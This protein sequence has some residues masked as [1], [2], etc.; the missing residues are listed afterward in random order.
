MDWRTVTIAVA[1]YGMAWIFLWPFL[2]KLFG[3][4]FAVAK[5]DA[6]I[7]GGRPTYGFLTF[8]SDPN[9]PLHGIFTSIAGH[10]VTDWLFMVGLLGIGVAL[11]LGIG[12]R[13]ACWSGIVMLV[14]M[15]LAILPMDSGTDHN[16]FWDDHVM[17]AAF[18]AMLLAVDAGKHWGL[19]DWWARRPFVQRFPWLR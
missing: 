18:L 4:G 10:P 8:G 2:D 9:N 7:R 12:M 3:L 5:D 17:Y 15:W 16:P 11:A 13:I 1:R 19:A 14:L 6:W